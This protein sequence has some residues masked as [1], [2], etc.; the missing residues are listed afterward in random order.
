MRTKT[1]LA[2]LMMVAGLGVAGLAAPASAQGIQIGPGGV[3]VDPGYRE[4]GP[5]DDVDLSRGEAIRIARRQGLTDVDNVDRRGPRIIV[6]G[7]D[8]RGDD[9]TVV[10]DSRSGD[11]IDVRR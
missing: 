11:V 1:V 4:R 5:R 10:V 7:S 3:R 2:G 6:R 8:R 9:I